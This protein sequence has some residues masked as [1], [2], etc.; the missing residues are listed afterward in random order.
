MGI[1]TYAAAGTFWQR[2]MVRA[3]LKIFQNGGEISLELTIWG[4]LFF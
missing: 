3:F 4:C 2:S 1:I